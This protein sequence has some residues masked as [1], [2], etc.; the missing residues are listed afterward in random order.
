L[1]G[2]SRLDSPCIIFR[3]QRWKRH[4]LKARNWCSEK[5]IED[6]SSLFFLP[7][8]QTLPQASAALSQTGVGKFRF[9]VKTISKPKRIPQ[10]D[11][12]FAGRLRSINANTMP[13]ASHFT[14][15]LRRACILF[16]TAI[17]TIFTPSN[18]SAATSISQH[19]ITWTWT[20]DRQLGQY[21]NGDYW[22]V[23]PITMTSISPGSSVTGSG[24]VING[25]MIN[26]T[27][28]QYP[29]QGFDSHMSEGQGVG[30]SATLNRGRPGGS[31]LSGSNPLV[32][33]A[34]SSVCS[35]ISHPTDTN[36]PTL[37]DFAVLTVVSSAP[38][39]GSF[40]PPYCG[41]DKTHRWNKSSLNYGILKN[42]APV[43]GSPD[44]SAGVPTRSWVEIS[45]TQPGYTG[46]RASNNQPHYGRDMGSLLGTRFLSL[47]LNYSNAAKEGL[48]VWMVQ[49]GIDIYGAYSSNP[50]NVIWQDEAGI[51]LG[52]HAP[53]ALAALAL[54]DSNI[55]SL[56]SNWSK[57][58]EDRQIWRITQSDVG[59][60]LVGINGK[61]PPSRNYIQSDVGLP[62]W[63]IKHMSQP[64]NDNPDWGA[65]YRD[66]AYTGTYGLALAANL[67]TGMKALW[68]HDVFFD[69]GNRVNN[70]SGSTAG[71]AFQRAMWAAYRNGG[72]DLPPPPPPPSFSIGDRI[73]LTTNTNIRTTGTISSDTL[74]GSNPT[75]TLG[76]ITEG[77]Y[78]S[79]AN[80]FTWWKVDFDTGHDGWCGEDNFVASSVSPPS[81]QP[82]AA[83]SGLQSTGSDN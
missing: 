27:A 39:P 71:T 10:P 43:T 36:R 33:S 54:N 51:V 21:A 46:F 14:Q 56:A 5:Q 74:I 61:P 57:F 29:S 50:G 49:Y 12:A 37:T 35:V 44:P 38:A 42:L 8:C 80:S 60:T 78:A 64:Q 20:E 41:T 69:Y 31:A 25:T 53:V 6:T 30:W 3:K 2:N 79:S 40:R 7:C 28:A 76:T 15:A 18:A 22:V 73:E 63:G 82:P 48:Y 9:A 13:H 47:H 26:P 68:N 59:R 52:Q 45:S 58:A 81:P 17:S 67:T 70:I 75:G 65:I 34:G 1:D 55:A 16:G 66:V 83:P 72:T 32:V 62:E 24:R 11:F 4:F 77:P 19:G 23:G